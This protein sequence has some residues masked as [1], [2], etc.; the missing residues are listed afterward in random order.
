MTDTVPAVGG[1]PEERLPSGDD[2]GEE[3]LRY[4]VLIGP[5]DA[6]FCRRVSDALADGYVLHGSPS[7]TTR[8]GQ[9][10]LA[11]AVVLPVDGTA[12]PGASVDG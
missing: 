8:H 7:I 11:Q 4:R 2:V 6:G 10:T 12:G 3:R 5:D 9:V 1:L